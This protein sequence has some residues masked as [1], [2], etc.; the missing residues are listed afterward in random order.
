MIRLIVTFSDAGAMMGG[1]SQPDVWSEV[2]EV[3]HPALERALRSRL[4]YGAK[5][6]TYESAPQEAQKARGNNTRYQRHTNTFTKES[7]GPSSQKQRRRAD[8]YAPLPRPLAFVLRRSGHPQR[9]VAIPGPSEA[10]RTNSDAI[11]R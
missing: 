8:V 9:R 4:D 1:N 7:S 11:T 2:F 10:L 5:Q 3:E 6:I